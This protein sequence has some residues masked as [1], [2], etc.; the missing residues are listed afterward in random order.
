[1]VRS[2]LGQASSNGETACTHDGGSDDGL[3]D[4]ADTAP[5]SSADSPDTAAPATGPGTHHSAD[6]D[7]FF[8]AGVALTVV[9]VA[10]PTLL[11]AA[12]AN[13]ITVALPQAIGQAA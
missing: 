2:T 10:V 11:P 7:L 13:L 8:Q 6:A 3:A 4:T 5:G 9:T 12:P 1:M